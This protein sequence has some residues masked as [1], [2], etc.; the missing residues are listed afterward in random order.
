MTLVAR[1]LTSMPARSVPE[2]LADMNKAMDGMGTATKQGITSTVFGLEA[3]SAATVLLNKA[4]A[5]ELQN[6]AKQLEKTG[7][8]QAIAAKMNKTAQGSLK[9]LGSAVESIAITV[10]NVLLPPLASIAETVASAA[11]VIDAFAQQFPTLTKVI[12]IGTAALI[13]MKIAAIAGGY[14]WTFIAGAGL[15]LKRVVDV[16]RVAYLLNTG[17]LTANT[18]AGKASVIVSKAMTVAQVAWAA[19]TKTVTGAQWLLNAALLANPIGLVIAGIAAL[20]AVGVV[21]YKNWDKIKTF[22]LNFWN[23][24]KTDTAGTLASIASMLFKFSPLGFIMKGFNE[25]KT[26]LSQ[27]S[28]VESGFSIMKTLGQGIMNAHGFIVDKVKDVFNQVREYLP[29]SDAKVGPFSELTKSGTAIMST[30]AQGVN[31]DNSL[32]NSVGNKFSA[33]PIKPM[34]SMASGATSQTNNQSSVTLKIDNIS[35]SVGGGAQ[36]EQQARAGVASGI[37]DAVKELEKT[38]QQKRRLSYE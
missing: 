9:R 30:L 21:L 23:S 15:A 18:A 34:S 6:Y 24:L 1:S 25:V 16:L 3:A 2:I 20:V 12:V 35:V 22:F 37:K 27:F 14:A 17:A 11:V 29:F 19:I 32:Q 5:G 33:T 10:G 38:L 4:G 8:A 13:A 26:W 31:K 28:L 36:T 7:T